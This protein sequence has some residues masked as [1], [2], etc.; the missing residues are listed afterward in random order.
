[1]F[2]KRLDTA[3]SG[4][5]CGVPSEVGLDDLRGLSQPK[6]SW[7][8]VTSAVL[9]PVRHHLLKDA[10][11]LEKHLTFPRYSL[12]AASVLELQN[13]EFPKPSFKGYQL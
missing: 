13:V 8:S 3:L 11:Y 1:M 9:R 10:G 4:W 12:A 6:L 7:D 2:Q 5:Q